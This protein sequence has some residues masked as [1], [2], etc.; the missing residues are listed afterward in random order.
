M[1][2][3]P[4]PMMLESGF[5]PV[6]AFAGVATDIENCWQL[7]AFFSV[8][9]QVEIAGHV[10]SWPALKVQLLNAKAFFTIK[11]S[12]D[13]RI[14]RRPFG[15]WPES[16]HFEI[17]PLQLRSSRL[18]LL[19]IGNSFKELAIEPDR[20]VF[21]KRLHHLVPGTVGT[22]LFQVGTEREKDQYRM[23]DQAS[24]Q[25]ANCF[26]SRV[27]STESSQRQPAW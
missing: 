12:G 21:E 2:R 25:E 16:Q 14:E 13:L 6:A 8:L 24:Q 19:A 10:K 1:R 15:H 17:L 23:E 18:P 27:D 11:R 7:G 22:R 5:V 9:G 4:H 20:F 26:H 3:E